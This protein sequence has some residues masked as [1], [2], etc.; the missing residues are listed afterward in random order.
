MSA[1]EDWIATMPDVPA[2]PLVETVVQAIVVLPSDRIRGVRLPC[3]SDKPGGC[4][5]N[6]DD[7]PCRI[8]AGTIVRA[9][10]DAIAEPS[11]AMF[12]A[13]GC[14]PNTSNLIC[15][16]EWC[17]VADVWRSMIAALRKEIENG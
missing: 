17:D 6:I 16:D 9:T 3:W 4:N 8:I 11:D 7:C 10:L 1:A 2:R 14:E 12:S 5:S 15:R 13:V